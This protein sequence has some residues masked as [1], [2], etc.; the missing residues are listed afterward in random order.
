MTVSGGFLS[1][2][3]RP[4]QQ[5]ANGGSQLTMSDKRNPLYGDGPL[6]LPASPS[7]PA[8]QSY[9]GKVD[10]DPAANNTIGRKALQP[11]PGGGAKVMSHAEIQAMLGKPSDST[12]NPGGGAKVMSHAEIQAML[13]SK[14]SA[15][16]EVRPVGLIMRI[17]EKLGGQI[18]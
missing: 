12:P 17:A 14:S 10:L 15:S 1:G 11:N 8:H 5:Q 3:V 16:S 6:A 4:S 9:S 18:C 13:A 2:P 7:A